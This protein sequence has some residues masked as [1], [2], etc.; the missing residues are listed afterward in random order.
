MTVKTVCFAC[1]D[2]VQ[3]VQLECACGTKMSV[4]VSRLTNGSPSKCSHCEATWLGHDTEEEKVLD[5]FV[6]SLGKLGSL[7][8]GRKVKVSLELSGA[9]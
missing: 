2:D 7:L 5:A 6:T 9:A 1:I 4:P 8:K 3:A